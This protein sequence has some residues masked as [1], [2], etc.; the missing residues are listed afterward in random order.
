MALN[1]SDSISGILIATALFLGTPLSVASAAPK[2][3][4]SFRQERVKKDLLQFV[5]K[6]H[7]M[8]SQDQK[9][10]SEQ[11]KKSLSKLHLKID[12]QQ[13][14]ALVP[15]L[16]TVGRSLPRMKTIVGRNVVGRRKGRAPCGI[17]WGGH[18][19]TKYFQKISFVGA[20]DGGSSTVLLLELARL[21][22]NEEPSLSG[23][24]TLWKDC[25]QI[26]AF[27]DGE[28]AVL[29]EWEDG[30]KLFGIPDNLYG[31]RHFAKS[32]QL[33]NNLWNFNGTPITLA[34]ILDMI[35]H[36]KQKLSITWGSDRSVAK[37]L[38]S[39]R[40]NTKIEQ[41]EFELED[42]HSPLKVKG[43]PFVHI[44]DWEN[45]KEWHTPQDNL[46]IISFENIVRT[47]D[48]LMR[49]LELPTTQRP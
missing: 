23:P 26:F 45:I 12:V 11:L 32:L 6:P 30:M 38:E 41:V 28:E 48:M 46:S 8:G 39:V 40:D 29:P 22:A 31:S 24:K 33:K 19:D 15:D 21:I 4:D 43:I 3:S 42:D 44:I 34:I 37:Q 47:V 25:A 14:D 16:T 1:A 10:Y 2:Y 20:N 9:E 18:F 35:G 36:E 5:L 27:F 49:F 7:P 17:L 13:F